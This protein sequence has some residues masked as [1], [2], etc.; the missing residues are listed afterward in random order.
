MLVR[1]EWW[2]IQICLAPESLCPAAS[3]TVSLE[4]GKYFFFVSSVSFPCLSASLGFPSS[5][6][7]C[8][9]SSSLFPQPFLSSG[10]LSW[11]LFFLP[12]R[13]PLH[14]SGRLALCWIHEGDL[15]WGL[16]AVGMEPT[17]SWL[18][19][20]LWPCCPLSC[21]EESPCQAQG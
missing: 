15:D 11:L 12:H 3:F 14:Q 16:G 5:L 6:S 13:C 21:L 7:A 10:L 4:G 19:P 9:H 1:P 8:V 2:C 17:C 20:C 18:C